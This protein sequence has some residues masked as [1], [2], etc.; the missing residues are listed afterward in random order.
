MLQITIWLL[1]KKID[2]SIESAYDLVVNENPK[3][4]DLTMLNVIS[5][6][7]QMGIVERNVF[8]K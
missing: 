7:V 8:F 6:L 1:L 4:K 2:K 3:V 5:A